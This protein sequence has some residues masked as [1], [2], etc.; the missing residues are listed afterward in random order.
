MCVYVCVCVS[1]FSNT[2]SWSSVSKVVSKFAASSLSFLFDS[3]L[4]R[5]ERKLNGYIFQ[6]TFV[7][8]QTFVE[9]PASLRP[10]KKTIPEESFETLLQVLKINQ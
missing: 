1:V 4:N 8:S 7:K 10:G 6:I 9:N 5:C 3:I 2:L